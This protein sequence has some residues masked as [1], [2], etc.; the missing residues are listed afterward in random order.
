[1]GESDASPAGV[2]PSRS[3][4]GALIY[5]FIA[6]LVGKLAF[7]GWA[8]R[9]RDLVQTY[10]FMLGD[11]QDWVASGLALAGFHVQDSVRPPGL[12]LLLAALDK[13]G[14]LTAFPIVQ[15]VLLAAAACLLFFLLRKR[16]GLEPAFFAAALL[17]LSSLP[18]TLS[19]PVHAD[20]LSGVL[21]LAAVSTFLYARRFPYAYLLAGLI[22]ALAALTQGAAFLAA[23]A[24]ALVLLVRRRQDL[25]NVWL[26]AGVVIFGSGVAA[27]SVIKLIRYGTAGDVVTR[28]WSLLGL[29]PQNLIF[30][31][32]ALLAI[33]GLPGLLVGLKG[34]V[35]MSRRRGEDDLLVLGTVVMVLGFL[36][37]VYGWTAERFLLVVLPLLAWVVAMGLATLG[38]RSQTLFG[39]LILVFAFLPL[40]VASPPVWRLW[41]FPSITIQGFGRVVPAEGLRQEWM[42]GP[43]ESIYRTAANERRHPGIDRALFAGAPSRG[44]LLFARGAYSRPS[45]LE[46]KRLGNILRRRFTPVPAG[47]YPLGW[48]GWSWSRRLSPVGR[49]CVLE[50]DLPAL[51][52]ILALTEGGVCNHSGSPRVPPGSYGRW[53]AEFREIAKEV[54]PGDP[55]IA[56]VGSER[57]DWVRLAPLALESANLVVVAPA[58][59][60]KSLNVEGKEASFGD[61]ALARG[62]AVGRPVWVLRRKSGAR[63]ADY[64][65]SIHDER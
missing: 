60:P 42:R 23:P 24:A 48:W 56:V 32:A 22:G 1:M 43:W 25:R 16:A 9:P 13:V 26:L 63:P 59:L 65:R 57:S 12:P 41:P 20:S 30:Y 14:A 27:W 50:L 55:F 37:L 33:L 54:G 47:L 7:V 53:I 34:A 39:V 58:R 15:Q 40:P 38:R 28:H 31:A 3:R 36:A 11:S 52:A 8:L 61:F 35:A 18:F 5:V 17:L 6:A 51:P 19:L 62:E 49:W 4:R 21:L 64:Q 2:E 46:S 44:V 29:H 45:Y 10:P